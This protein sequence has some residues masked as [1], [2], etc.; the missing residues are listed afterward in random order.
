[1]LLEFALAVSPHLG[2]D[3]SY[4][5]V[6]PEVRLSFSNST[7]VSAYYNSE[8]RGSI[9]VG[10][11]YEDGKFWVEGGVVAGYEHSPVLP[12]VRVGYGPVFFAPSYEVDNGPIG[13]F[14]LE[15]RW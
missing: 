1:M 8:R 5:E 3:N 13:V 4:N 11:K 12:F 10:Y 7:F 14:G 9:A 6:H 15:A 2:A